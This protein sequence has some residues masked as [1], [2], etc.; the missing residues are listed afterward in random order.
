MG[1]PVRERPVVGQEQHAGRVAVE[2]ADRHDADVAADEVD[3]GR[4]PLGVP[5]GRDRPPGLVQ[6]HV[7]QR[8]L[9]DLS[10][11]DLHDVRGLD[12]RVQLPG[13]PFTVTRPGLDQARRPRG[14]RRRRPGRGTR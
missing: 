10:P 4:P 7:A 2:A 11:V 13:A 9:P 12:E 6:E 5:R 14:A 8:L 1:E 3:D